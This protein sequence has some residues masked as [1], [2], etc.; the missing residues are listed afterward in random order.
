VTLFDVHCAGQ[1]SQ[2][3]G[4]KNELHDAPLICC[5]SE[6]Q[7]WPEWLFSEASSL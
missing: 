4:E 1:S 7:G 6:S 2:G 3:H 5:R